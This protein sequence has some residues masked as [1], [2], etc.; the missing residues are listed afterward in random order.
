V[1]L[2]QGEQSGVPV[3]ARV[4]A[5]GGETVMVVEDAIAALK[6]LRDSGSLEAN[7]VSRE[8][9]VEPTEAEREAAA[10]AAALAN[11][12]ATQDAARAKQAA[13]QRAQ[14]QAAQGGLGGDVAPSASWV[15]SDE[16]LADLPGMD[17]V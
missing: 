11:A 6:R 12:T 16:P 5:V 1:C 14:A 10:A 4:L 13:L 17:Q 9:K 8:F 7:V 2:A 15:P 3:G